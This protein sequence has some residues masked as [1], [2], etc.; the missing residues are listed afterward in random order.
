M[1]D[2][3]STRRLRRVIK[4]RGAHFAPIGRSAGAM[5]EEL[6]ADVAAV[7]L[8]GDTPAAGWAGWALDDLPAAVDR[9]GHETAGGWIPGNHYLNASAP[10]L[11][12][13]QTGGRKVELYRASQWFGAGDY[14]PEEATAAW[15]MLSVAIGSA[16]SGA[17]LLATPAT[18]ARELFL[19]GIPAG[20]E[21]PV[22]P[23]DLQELIRA[24]SGQ[25]RTEVVPEPAA[26][27][28]VNAW[29][30][31]A[32]PTMYEYDGRLMYAALC[33]GLPMGVPTHDAGDLFMGQQRGR[34]R[35]RVTVPRD[36]LESFGLLGV[37]RDDG[38][39][40][41]E[42]PAERGRTFSTWCDGAELA[43]V[44]ACGWDVRILE[45]LLFP[46]PEGSPRGPLDTWAQKLTSLRVELST[47]GV[48]RPE[49]ARVAALVGQ[50]VRALLL[51]GIGSFHGRPQ[52]HTEYRPVTSTTP[53]PD[54]ARNA[55][56]DSD[57]LVYE[58]DAEE[59]TSWRA[60]LSHPEWSA[61]I[62][63][64]ARARL[65]SGP[66]ETGALHRAGEVVGFR[67]DA[68]YLTQRQTWHDDGRPGRFRL[69]RVCDT[70][71]YPWPANGT[72]LVA[73]RNSGRLV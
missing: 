61:A 64:R 7:Y 6:P 38:S 23:D 44:Y 18:T 62:W 50:A 49:F 35:V 59:T 70:G 8:V 42:Y 20:R 68:I 66:G 12:Y 71:P 43:I 54:R 26:F 58:L 25:G 5:L 9:L 45:R 2:S 32:L 37:P 1:G 73:L 46:I 40:L 34:Y 29:Q 55:R 24:T 60:A 48:T 3:I 51:H 28:I 19:R 41:W 30:N 33:W 53:I 56:V 52:T 10:V 14:S 15:A 17:T 47:R 72:E 69:R 13:Q 39:R 57:W 27:R 67:T 22:L 63:S 21:Y 36:W 65:L 16:F 11:R 4:S 31:G